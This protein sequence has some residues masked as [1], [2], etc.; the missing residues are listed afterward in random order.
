MGDTFLI[1][2]LR[3]KRSAVAGRIV[4]LRPEADRLRPSPYR[5]GAKALWA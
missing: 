1:Y 3:E 5:R 4:D 2:G